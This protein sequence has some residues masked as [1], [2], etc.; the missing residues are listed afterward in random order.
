MKKR[1]YAL[2]MAAVLAASLSGCGDSYRSSSGS[3]KNSEANYS[4][5]S[6]AATAAGDYYGDY[7]YD[8]GDYEEYASEEMADGDYSGGTGS[9]REVPGEDSAG[10]E[11]ARS[12][13]EL[14]RIL[15]EKLV[16]NYNLSFYVMDEDINTIVADVE[17][18]V[19]RYDGFIEYSNQSEKYFSATVRIP[20]MSRDNF[21]EAVSEGRDPKGY[22][23]DKSVSNLS[24]A[25]T[26]YQNNY[27]IAKSNYEAYSQV[28]GQA[29][30][31]DDILKITQYVNDAK[32][33][34]DYYTRLMND[35]DT[36][37]SYST[38]VLDI[39]VK[40]STYVPEPEDLT[41]GQKLAMSFEQGL[42]GFIDTLQALAIWF[43][44]SIFGLMVFAII[45][46]IIIL[47]IRSIIKKN[48]AREEKR[49]ERAE[50]Y[51]KN[52]M[53]RERMIIDG[54]QAEAMDRAN[55]RANAGANANPNANA[56]VNPNANANANTNTN[57]NANANAN[58][59]A[60]TDKNAKAA[61]TDKKANNKANNKG[62]NN[63]KK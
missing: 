3:A 45:V 10:D 38:I 18:A 33:E 59:D 8:Y 36:D 55:A 56:N 21:V 26:N 35:I 42:N 23:L 28:L 17:D 4:M 6:A 61:D 40:E 2:L 5:D 30:D 44:G 48:R 1:V 11:T 25:Y 37:V 52:R 46:V 49:M 41:F 60:N 53:D 19:V 57:A 51:A 7:D 14:K 15:Q 27:E 20:T 32:G 50:A 24:S 43:V 39:S 47:I 31:V 54:V 34:M 29:R 12:A 22:K 9:T 16:Y 58:V 62:N 13:A 63:S